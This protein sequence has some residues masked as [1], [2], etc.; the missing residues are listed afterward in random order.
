MNLCIPDCDPLLQDCPSFGYACYP[1]SNDRF[2]CVLDLS[3]EDGKVNDPCFLDCDFDCL[4]NAGLM[5]AT[6]AFVGMGCEAED[7]PGCCTPFCALP[8]GSCP[9][10][11]QECVQYFDPEQL[12]VDD[13]KLDIG[14]CGLPL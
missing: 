7:P 14:V 8:D 13:P 11:D 9:D 1:N 10:A 3:G 5:C 6:A 12:P 4:C 2:T